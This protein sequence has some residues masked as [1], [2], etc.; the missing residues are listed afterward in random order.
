MFIA[1]LVAKAELVVGVR[2]TGTEWTAVNDADGVHDFVE[3]SRA[4]SPTR[5]V[6]EATGWYTLL[7]VAATATPSSSFITFCRPQLHEPLKESVGFAMVFA[8]SCC[9]PS[10][11]D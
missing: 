3:R 4:R 6:L 5:I 2:P 7:S 1:I 8:S 10:R 9:T 11:N